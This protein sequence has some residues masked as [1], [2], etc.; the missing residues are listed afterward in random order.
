MKL[1][2]CDLWRHGA[3]SH[4]VHVEHPECVHPLPAPVA[5]EGREPTHR[6]K[7]CGALW[8][9]LPPTPLGGWSLWSRSCGPCCDNAEMGEQ[10]EPIS[11]FRRLC[12]PGPMGESAAPE[13]PAP[14]GEPDDVLPSCEVCDDTR[15]VRP[16]RYP[17]GVREE[18]PEEPCPS[19]AAAPAKDP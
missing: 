10:I 6:C 2:T 16:L 7:V 1:V 14:L 5:P 12:D 17:V 19:C 4:L 15:V 3:N 9:K 8:V 18:L 11:D 13:T